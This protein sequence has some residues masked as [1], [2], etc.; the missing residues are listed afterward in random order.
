MLAVGVLPLAMMFVAVRGVTH[1]RIVEKE[2]S[3]RSQLVEELA[4][5]AG[6]VMQRAS[7]ALRSLPSN[8]KIVRHGISLEERLEEMERLA[9]S[10][11]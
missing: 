8:Q 4:R 6:H 9:A 2:Y 11:P 3:K 10:T 1:R 5:Q 7:D